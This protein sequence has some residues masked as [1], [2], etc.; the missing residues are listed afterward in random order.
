MTLLSFQGFILRSHWLAV[1]VDGELGCRIK[2]AVALI[3]VLIVNPYFARRQIERLRLRVPVGF[4]ERNLAVR[5]K[6]DRPSSRGLYFTDVATSNP[7]VP[8]I[9]IRPT[10]FIF[11]SALTNPSF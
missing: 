4:S 5:N 10:A 1:L 11:S 2:D 6:T 7:S 3:L 8:G 9:V